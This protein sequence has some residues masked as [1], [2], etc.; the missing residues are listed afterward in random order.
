R[1]HLELQPAEGRGAGE[2]L[3]RHPGRPLRDETLEARDGRV[4]DVAP[5]QQPALDLRAPDTERV[6]GEES[7]VGARGRD[8]RG[9]QGGGRPVH[10]RAKGG[11]PPS[12]ARLA[13]RAASSASTAESTTGSRSPSRTASS[14]WAL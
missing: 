14:W 9:V 7:G 11:H 5:E 12:P 8:V 2:V 13:R 4:V 10:L 3:Q 1:P 6:S